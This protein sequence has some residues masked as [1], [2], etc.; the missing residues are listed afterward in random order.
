MR[1]CASKSEWAKKKKE[2]KERYIGVKSGSVNM[3]TN[4]KGKKNSETTTG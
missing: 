2:E 1:V 3:G 4:E